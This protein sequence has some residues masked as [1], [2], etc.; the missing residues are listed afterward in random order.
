MWDRRFGR[1]QIV[2]PITVAAKS[3]HVR[4]PIQ[5]CCAPHLVRSVTPASFSAP[6]PQLSPPFCTF[7]GD[8]CF[9]VNSKVAASY[10]ILHHLRSTEGH[11][12]RLASNP[13]C[14]SAVP[15]AHNFSFASIG[16]QSFQSP[17]ACLRFFILRTRQLD[18]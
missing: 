12:A 11:T 9:N 15:I 13:Q 16:I 1:L 2:L 18:R 4:Q 3:L 14:R 8:A 6:I 17:E 5:Y 7:W 10:L